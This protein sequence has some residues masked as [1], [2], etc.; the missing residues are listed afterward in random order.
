MSQIKQLKNTLRKSLKQK[1]SQI[2]SQ[3]LHRQSDKVFQKLTQLKEFQN[4]E[5]IS[6]YI[7]ME[8]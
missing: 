3:E 2:E 8:S 1:L 5:N 6:V 7:S 4:S